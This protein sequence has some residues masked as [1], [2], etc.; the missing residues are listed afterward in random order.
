LLSS[1]GAGYETTRAAGFVGFPTA[2]KRK[3]QPKDIAVASI[4]KDPKGNRSIQF[5][6]KDRKRRTVRIGK[7][8]QRQ[9]EAV[10][11]HVERLDHAS[12]TGHPVDSATARWLIQIDKKLADRLAA[13]GLVEKRDAS[14][15]ATFID[16]Y[17]AM[18]T[19]VKPR[20]RDLYEQ[21]RRSLLEFFDANQD[22]TK[23]TPGDADAWQLHL[24]EQGLAQNTIR[25]RCGRA[26]QFLKAAVRQKLIEENPFADLKSLVVGN[27]ERFYFI[28]PT[29][30]EQVIEACP[31]AEWRLIFA[32]S[33]YGGL[34]CPSEHLSL[35]W[36]DVNW[37]H[38]RILV[39]SPKTE[40][41]AGG[42]SRLVP[43]FPELRPYPEKAFE[44]ATPGSEFVITR[45]R[46]ADK[47]LRTQL[48]RIIYRA[49][50]KPWP[51]VFQNLRSTRET[52]LAE[53]FPLH[54]VCKWI[55]NSQP[56]A[57]KHYL[58]VTSEHFERAAS[59]PEKAL[60]NPVQQPLECTGNA[61]QV[62]NTAHEK[63]PDDAGV[64][65][66]LSVLTTEQ[67][68]PI[69]TLFELCCAWCEIASNEAAALC[70]S[71][72]LIQWPD[73]ADLPPLARR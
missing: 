39:N 24:K 11:V 35:K 37:E 3:H 60:Q 19:D 15:L 13:V 16:S 17:I 12:I 52:E 73:V 70:R 44:Q 9:A 63:T 40:H 28:T 66:S 25:R 65:E 7:C 21:T 71:S 62:V 59:I 69:A 2:R 67:N 27:P 46:D 31:D 23:I 26:K 1:D 8:S 20:T 6:G 22:I 58:Q 30:A 43:M 56:V 34:R 18:R 42:E 54:V 41:L 72:S 51:K 36:S 64:C 53:Q 14:T 45:Y 50:L 32:L 10:K 61:A 4:T 48:H 29:E 49:G 57:A 68:S 38:G 55:G 5:V 47:N 33:R